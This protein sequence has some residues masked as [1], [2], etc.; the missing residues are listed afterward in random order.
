[1]SERKCIF[2]LADGARLDVFTELIRRGD[3][4]NIQK[5]IVEPG[6]LL[7]AVTVFPSTTGPAYTPY[8]LGRF[9]GRCNLPGIRWFDR[10]YYETNPFSLRRFRSYAG[11]QSFL[12][13]RDIECDSPTLFGMVPGSV[14]IL[15][16]ITPD[17]YPRGNNK[18]RYLKYYLVVKSHFTDRSNSVEDVAGKI[19]LE[20]LE[21]SP[22]FVFCVFPGIDAY[23]HRYHPFHGKVMESYARLD[24]YVCKVARRIEQR[25]E[26]SETLFIVGSDHGLTSTH[27]HFDSLGFLRRRGLRPLYY[28]NV[29]RHFLDADS[30]VMVSGNSMA[31]YYFKNSDGWKRHTLCEEITDVVEDLRCRPEVDI[32]CART[33]DMRREVKIM[34][35]DGEALVSMD[36]EGSVC[37]RNVSGDPLGYGF[38]RERIDI[39][40]L[41]QLTIDSDYPDAPLQILQLFESPRTGDVV[42]SARPGYDLR[43]THENPEHHGSHG[44][45]H[46]EHMVVPVLISRR[47]KYDYAR[48]ADIFPSIVRY[49]GLEVPPGVDGRDILEEE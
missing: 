27:S 18:T 34:N 7:K 47:S 45:L 11:P 17:I 2:F 20:S 23:S 19:L 31:H 10:R 1:M 16:E 26:L 44:S 13:N 28:T 8:L 3:L 14:S 4:D 29:L 43:A 36:G 33:S 37:Y 46:K 9:P 42:V 49:L 22:R 21:A 12:I 15:N 40:E 41:L 24:R 38:S 35:Q 6:E 5:Y 30:S 39:Q 48:T 25:G 32:V